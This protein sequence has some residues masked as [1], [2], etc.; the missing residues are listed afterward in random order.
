MSKSFYIFSIFLLLCACSPPAD[1]KSDY[2][3]IDIEERQALEGAKAK[4]SQLEAEL[5]KAQEDKVLQL[6]AEL[7]NARQLLT[8][9]QEKQLLDAAKEAQRSLEAELLE[10]AKL[11][12]ENDEI[13]RE[14][15]QN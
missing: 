14:K 11:E 6:E 8:E 9:E 12:Q 4:V 3:P 15:L 1:N 7:Q 5:E 13:E 2:K 10:S